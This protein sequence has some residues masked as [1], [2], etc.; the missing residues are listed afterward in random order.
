MSSTMAGASMR[1]R[2]SGDPPIRPGRQRAAS[3][4]EA[5][6]SGLEAAIQLA[7]FFWS[8]LADVMTIGLS[9]DQA[10]TAVNYHVVPMTRPEQRK[11]GQGL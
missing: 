8:D 1:R 5:E 3:I 11:L 4:G 10:T 6:R 2:P 7:L 9:P